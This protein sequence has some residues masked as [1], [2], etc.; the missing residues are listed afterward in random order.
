[1]AED[2]FET[3]A[4]A[5]RAFE[6]RERERA[7]ALGMTVEQLRSMGDK[8]TREA[9]DAQRRSDRLRYARRYVTDEDFAR[10]VG[11]RCDTPA[12]AAVSSWLATSS[13][14]LVLGGGRGTG[15]TVAA[16]HAIATCGGQI[17]TSV[18]IGRAWR[19]EHDEARALRARV[20][21][22]GLLVVD[23]VGTELDREAVKVAMQELINARQSGHRTI[24]TTNLARGVFD[25]A[26]DERT[27]ERIHHR[28][29]F[30]SLAGQ[31]MREGVRR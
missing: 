5:M 27:I 28:G 2:L 21:G 22:A 30:V 3:I 1:M 23:D 8:R 9:D 24:V 4:G 15:K 31:S 10:V 19:N 18:E 11:R 25:R 13:A 20:L 16:L 12:A 29:V 17:V 6:D 14:F 26:F 7:G